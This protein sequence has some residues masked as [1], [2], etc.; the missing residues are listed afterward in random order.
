MRI[1]VF[2]LRPFAIVFFLA[3]TLFTLY[4]QPS[5]LVRSVY[6]VFDP[7]IDG[8]VA[9]RHEYLFDDL[10]SPVAIERDVKEAVPFHYDWETYGMPWYYP[11]AEEAFAVMAGDCKTQLMVLASMLESKGIAY[12]VKVSPTHV[13]VEYE[14]RSESDIENDDVAMF[15]AEGNAGDGE[16]R[17]FTLPRSID[18]E[19]SFR[20]FWT[21]FWHYMPVDRKVSLVS[22]F[23]IFVILMALSGVVGERRTLK[24]GWSIARAAF[25]SSR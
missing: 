17:A 4:P 22:G 24:P 9:S 20:A 21:A 8:E 5:D 11:S 12:T 2:P 16:Q 6:R 1:P 23:M 13:W 14:G 10:S 18:L 15:S 25:H 19:R 7:P 3:W